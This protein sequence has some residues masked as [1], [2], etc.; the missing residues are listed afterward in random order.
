M[1]DRDRSSGRSGGG[2]SPDT[3][4]LD[5]EASKLFYGMAQGVT[6]EALSELMRE[7]AKRHLKEA[8][9]DRIEALA[10]LAVEELLADMEANL[11]I[12]SKIAARSAGRR[13]TEERLAKIFQKKSESD[14]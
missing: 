14:E 4:F 11:D 13:A 6:R 5:L 9:G 2:A 12:E 1:N 8:W 10:A 7:A 3:R